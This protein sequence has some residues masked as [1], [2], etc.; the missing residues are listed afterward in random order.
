MS[1]QRTPKRR[2]SSVSVEE[3]LSVERLK[4][5]M[6]TAKQTLKKNMRKTMLILRENPLIIKKKMLL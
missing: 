6:P 3:T 2:K 5:E 4:K 1:S